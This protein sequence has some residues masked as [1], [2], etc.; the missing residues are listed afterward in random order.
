MPI[1]DTPSVSSASSILQ[2][3]P[4]RSRAST[5]PTDISSTHLHD[6]DDFVLPT[7]TEEMLARRTQSDLASAE[8]GKKLLQGW[9]MLADECPNPACHGVPLVRPP[10]RL[11]RAGSPTKVSSNSALHSAWCT[12]FN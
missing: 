5:P 6:D 3:H 10:Q 8:I 1:A 7:P 4:S 9:T 12:I 2:S 11:N